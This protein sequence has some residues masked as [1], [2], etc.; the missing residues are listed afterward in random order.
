MPVSLITPDIIPKIW[1]GFLVQIDKALAL[2]VGDHYSADYY[3]EEVISGRMQMWAYHDGGLI[4]IGII[5]VIDYPKHKTVFIELL[6]GEKLDEW[7][8]IVE[9]LLQE[10]AS[11]IGAT[12]IEASCRPGLVKKLT[13][14][15]PIATLM[16]LDN[17]RK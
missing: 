1:G 7:L 16:R 9:P 13:K 15:R 3:Y 2:G 17:G 4:A 6:A 12:T 11:Q 5:S 8:G 14:W 10:Y